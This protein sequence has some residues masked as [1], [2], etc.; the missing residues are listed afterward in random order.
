METKWSCG[1]DLCLNIPKAKMGIVFTKTDYHV[2]YDIFMIN[3]AH[4]TEYI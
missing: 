2:K 1:I 3:N 4:D